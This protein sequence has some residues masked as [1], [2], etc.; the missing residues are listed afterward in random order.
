MRSGISELNR[1]ESLRVSLPA[2]YWGVV[3]PAKAGIQVFPFLLDTRL[4]GC[5]GSDGSSDPLQ[6]AG[7]KFNLSPLDG[8]ILMRRTAGWNERS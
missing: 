1:R 6:F 5:D 2:P 3:I 7:P 4:R 8:G